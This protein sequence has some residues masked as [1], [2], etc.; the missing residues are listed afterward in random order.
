[1]TQTATT[2][3]VGDQA[4]DVTLPDDRNQPTRLSELWQR[5]PIVLVFVRHSGCTLCLDHAVATPPIGPHRINSSTSCGWVNE[6]AGCRR[7]L[8]VA[9]RLNAASA[10]RLLT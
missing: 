5:Q 8:N 4:P 10:W 9:V 1:M 2:L 3:S 7:W 6:V